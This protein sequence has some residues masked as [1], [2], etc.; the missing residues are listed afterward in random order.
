MDGGSA[1]VRA[2]ASDMKAEC[3]AGITQIHRKERE[4]RKD[5][6]VSALRSL[7]P[8]RCII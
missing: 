6:V 3:C 5:N 1:A 7:R 2:E 8:L 4:G